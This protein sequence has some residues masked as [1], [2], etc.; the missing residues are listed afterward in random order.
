MTRSSST[1][2]LCSDH[3]DRTSG[4]RESDDSGV[5]SSERRCTAITLGGLAERAGIDDDRR[6]TARDL[7]GGTW[8]IPASAVWPTSV[9]SSRSTTP[10]P[11]GAATALRRERAILQGLSDRLGREG[12]LARAAGVDLPTVQGLSS[13]DVVVLDGRVGHHVPTVVMIGEH[14]LRW[15]AGSTWKRAV[16]RALYATSTP[17]NN[18]SRSELRAVA[19]ELATV[20]LTVG[21]VDVGTEL[22]QASGVF[23]CSVQLL[24]CDDQQSRI[25]ATAAASLT[26]AATAV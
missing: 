21:V 10:Q 15:G 12:V 16:D 25:S 20:G 3:L 22:L 24:L 7:D 23:R 8:S 5:L 18:A 26:E 2:P 17:D 4:S 14:V 19:A 9:S 1:E 11:V 6:T 13:G